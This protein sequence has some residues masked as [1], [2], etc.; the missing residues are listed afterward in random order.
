MEMTSN[1]NERRFR[2]WLANTFLDVL[3][4]FHGLKRR[5]LGHV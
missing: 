4:Y 1:Q 5:F 3:L 2:K